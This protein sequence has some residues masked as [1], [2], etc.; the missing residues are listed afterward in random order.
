[1]GADGLPPAEADAAATQPPLPAEPIETEAADKQP[2]SNGQ[3]S[4][5]APADQKSSAEDD[6]LLKVSTSCMV[7]SMSV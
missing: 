5:S 6:Y 1:M 2:E 7:A 3:P 4:T